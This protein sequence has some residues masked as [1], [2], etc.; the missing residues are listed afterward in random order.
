MN[1]RKIKMRQT[2]KSRFNTNI[3]EFTNLSCT[4][5]IRVKAL[6]AFRAYV[7]RRPCRW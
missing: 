3:Q 7:P 2:L 1:K 6:L 4:K 5:K